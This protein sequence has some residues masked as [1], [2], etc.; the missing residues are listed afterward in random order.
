MEI[1]ASIGQVVGHYSLV[2]VIQLQILH[3]KVVVPLSC[4][5]CDTYLIHNLLNPVKYQEEKLQKGKT[6]LNEGVFGRTKHVQCNFM[7]HNE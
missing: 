1:Q 2:R 4:E 5:H 7:L 3:I 6:K